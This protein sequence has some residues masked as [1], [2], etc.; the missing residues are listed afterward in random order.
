MGTDGLV[1]T[2]ADPSAPALLA[3]AGN[4]LH[5][6]ISDELAQ[7]SRELPQVILPPEASDLYPARK[8]SVTGSNVEACIR[9]VRVRSNDETVRPL[10]PDS[11]WLPTEWET[12]ATFIFPGQESQR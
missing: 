4:W 1:A 8:S 6:A 10:F 11:S 12:V 3:P 5:A 7:W 9:A 2:V